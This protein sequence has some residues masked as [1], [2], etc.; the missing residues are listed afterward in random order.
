MSTKHLLY[1]ALFASL[2]AIGAQ[3]RLPIGPVPV[4]MQVPMVLLA[5]LMLGPKLG[6]LSALVYMLMG[7]VGLPVFAGGGG[8]GSLVSPSFGFIVG[9]IPAAWLAGF[10]AAYKSSSAR[11]ISFALAATAVIFLFG[12][13]YFIF[14]MNVVLDTPMSA[15]A[16]FKVAVLPFILKDVAVAVVTSM[17]ARMLHTRGLHLANG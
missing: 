7:L 8:I 1:V 13:L 9:Y 6:A 3:I 11:A 2:I 14:I 17:F 10:G 15:V 4:T 5:G 12:F 16:A